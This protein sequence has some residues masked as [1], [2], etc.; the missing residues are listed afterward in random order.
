MG[1]VFEI[2]SVELESKILFANLQFLGVATVSVCW[3]E[4]IRRYLKLR[5]VPRAITAFLVAHA[6][7]HGGNG[8]R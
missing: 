4:M 2:V 5:N 6:G 1:Y 3:W 8:L 7:G